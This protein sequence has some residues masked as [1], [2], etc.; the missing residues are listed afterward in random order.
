MAKKRTIVIYSN[1]NEF[2]AK[3]V[4]QVLA[5]NY[6]AEFRESLQD[7]R[8]Q[9]V[10]SERGEVQPASAIPGKDYFPAAFLT[11]HGQSQGVNLQY[12]GRVFN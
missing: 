10:C 8:G 5:H 1:F 2:G 9:F 7:Y 12:L 6:F 11:L 3:L 4:E